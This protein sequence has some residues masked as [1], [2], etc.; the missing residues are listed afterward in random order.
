LAQDWGLSDFNSKHAVVANFSYQLPFRVDSKFAGAAVNGWTFDGIG[1]FTSGMPLTPRL[2]SS[3]SRDD[4][5]QFVE[6]PNLVP[7][8]SNNPTSGVSAGCPGFAAGTPLGNANNWYDPCA[9]VLPTPGTYGNLGRNTIIGPGV[10]D[11]DLALEKKFNLYE[12]ASATFRAE[13][14]N[15]ANHANF[16]LPNPTALASNGTA[17]SSAGQITSTTTT[18]RQIQFALRISF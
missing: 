11:V 17:K 10:A 3:V 6:R 13:V 4:S 7:G 5:T 2:S 16:G 1:T 8:F 12:K 15:V 18:S 14:F 9:F